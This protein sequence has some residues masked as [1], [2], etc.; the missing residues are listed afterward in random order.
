MRF[1][2][3]IG[4]KFRRIKHRCLRDEMRHA[5]TPR[6]SAKPCGGFA[7]V[8]IA[9]SVPAA[10]IAG[11]KNSQRAEGCHLCVVLVSS[12]VIVSVSCISVL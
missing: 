7:T 12:N 10:S 9:D 2:D 5:D 8:K 1:F 3:V 4:V 6:I 11:T